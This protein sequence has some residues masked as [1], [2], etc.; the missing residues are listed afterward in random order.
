[1]ADGR[2]Q[3]IFGFANA[4]GFNAPA[5]GEPWDAV[6]MNYMESAHFPA[7]TLT[8]R[9]GDEVYLSLTNVGMINRPDLFDPH[10]VHWHGFPNAAAIFDGVPDASIIINMGSTLTYY[11]QVVEAGTFMY[12]C[13][14][15]ATEHMQM[16]M[17]GNLY[18]TPAQDGTPTG[19]FSRFAYNDGDGSTGY[20][21]AYPIQIGAFDPVF[22]EQHIGVQPL[23]FANM[24]DKYPMFNGR[25]YPDTVNTGAL[26]PA[27]H[28]RPG[29][30]PMPTLIAATPGQRILLRVSSLSTTSFHTLTVLGI[31]MQVVGKGSRKLGLT[32]DISQYYTTNAITLGGG[33]AMD[34]ILDTAG[35]PA[36]TY[37]LYTTNLDHLAN[38]AEDYG[39]M[40]TE[41][42]IQP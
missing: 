10:S 23:P 32:N 36:G 40:M 2:E 26:D 21:V 4:T 33:Q 34:V 35:V 42:R 39:G 25:G 15:E 28:P 11:Y 1:M 41:I 16:G 19:G 27:L 7:P 13:H 9:E 18:V 20:D 31:P 12:H 37:F 38:E 6:M 22:H 3:Y 30:A 8:F 5:M 24:D 17:L 14:V 29:A